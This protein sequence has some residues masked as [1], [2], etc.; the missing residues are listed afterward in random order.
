MPTSPEAL[1]QELIQCTLALEESVQQEDSDPDKWNQLLENRQRVIDQLD[2]IEDKSWLDENK[3]DILLRIYRKDQ[4]ILPLMQAKQE[5]V[6]LKLRE[7][8]QIRAASNQYT[9]RY[10]A[11]GYGAFFDKRK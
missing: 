2:K 1:L 9:N 7:I 4:Q 6:S 11:S 3:K 5:S 10:A 8:Q